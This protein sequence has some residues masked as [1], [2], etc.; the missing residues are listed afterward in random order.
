M[1]IPATINPKAKRIEYRPP[2]STANPYLLFSAL[3]MAG[4]DGIQS[5][6]DPDGYSPYDE[7][8][9]S[10]DLPA[11]YRDRINDVPRSLEEALSELDKDRAFL[12][13]GNVFTDD[14][15]D[16]YIEFKR[17]EAEQVRICPTPIEFSLYYG[18]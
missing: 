7:D 2:D 15:I 1:R 14:L 5:Q 3:L 6:L 12:L 18:V 8:L 11:R 9:Y 10:D 4:L 17:R 13:K 16:Q